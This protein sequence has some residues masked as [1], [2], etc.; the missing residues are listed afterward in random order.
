MRSDSDPL[1]GSGAG[2][3]PLAGGK[4]PLA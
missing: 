1:H 3:A 2:R 4:P